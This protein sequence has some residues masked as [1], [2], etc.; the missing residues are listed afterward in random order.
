MKVHDIYERTNGEALVTVHA[1]DDDY[2]VYE[3][4]LMD[5]D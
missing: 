1:L 5:L 3:S 4:E 2:V